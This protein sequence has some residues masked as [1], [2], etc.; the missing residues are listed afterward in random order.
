MT[1]FREQTIA[2][3]LVN[4]QY[5]GTLT[6]GAKVTINTAGDIVIKDYKTGAVD[7]GSGGTVGRTTKPDAISTTSVDLVIDQEKSFDFQIDDIDRAQAAGSLE[8]YT[9]GAGTSLAEDADKFILAM[10]ATNTATAHKLTG[11]AATDLS[12]NDAFNAI[13]TMRK[14]LNKAKVPQGGRVLFV[15]AEFEHTL[16]G[17]DSKLT[18]VDVSGSPEGLRNAALGGLLGFTIY[19]TENLPELTKPFAMAAYLPSV[20]FVSQVTETE[21][22]RAQDTFADRLRGLHVYGGKVLRAGIGLTSYTYTKT[23]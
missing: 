23:A 16:L 1:S 22:M 8:V 7:N 15:N 12:G 10:M 4:R 18:S 11:T 17:A 9:Q 2:A 19:S 20:C 6:R 13:R 14:T 21:A 5:E 3:G